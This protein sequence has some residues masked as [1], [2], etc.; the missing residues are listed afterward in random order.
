MQLCTRRKG[1]SQIKITCGA[2]NNRQTIEHEHSL[3]NDNYDTI[4]N[5]DIDG[6]HNINFG[7]MKW[8]RISSKLHFQM[9]KII[10]FL[11]SNSCF[12][13]FNETSKYWI[14]G[15]YF[16]LSALN[17]KQ[18]SEST[19]VANFICCHFGNWVCLFVCVY[20]MWAIAHFMCAPHR[21][22]LMG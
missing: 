7:Y 17:W 4:V 3:L 13:N 11:N 18:L 2:Q 6:R 12:E 22:H 21:F 19:N 8:I 1:G 15:R 9:H 16:S 20:L 10:I 14:D 5:V